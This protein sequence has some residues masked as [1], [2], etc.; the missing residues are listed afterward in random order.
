[1]VPIPASPVYPLPIGKDF[2]NA[3]AR[4]MGHVLV[5]V[6]GFWLDGKSS[7]LRAISM[8]LALCVVGGFGCALLPAVPAAAQ[9][10]ND[11]QPTAVGSTTWIVT[12]GAGTEYGPSY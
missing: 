8:K 7:A 5:V 1:A 9:S 11:K 4:R 12:L 2:S 3:V 10:T 6:K